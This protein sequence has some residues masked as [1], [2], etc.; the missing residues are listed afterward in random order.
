MTYAPSQAILE[1]ESGMR[2]NGLGGTPTVE[3]HIVHKI[4]PRKV[5]VRNQTP[6]NVGTALNYC[7]S[8]SKQNTSHH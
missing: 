4:P 3:G 7:M 6:H 5:E 2:T 1:L 8:Q